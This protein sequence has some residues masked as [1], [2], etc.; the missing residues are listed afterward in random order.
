MKKIAGL[1]FAVLVI[2]VLAVTLVGCS[3]PLTVG[4][5]EPQDGATI[6]D[7]TVQV[8]GWV[9]D[10]KANLWINDYVMT[11]TKTTRNATFA[12]T[13]ELVEGENT[14][15]VTAARGKPDKWKD[16]VARTVTVTYSPQ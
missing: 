12:T 9:S 6:A 11:L 14:I 3:K 15:T 5:Y 13:L 10:A 8:R 1:I 7:S 2:S 4:F 16:I